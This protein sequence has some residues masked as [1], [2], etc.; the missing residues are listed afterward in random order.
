[1]KTVKFVGS[2]TDTLKLVKLCIELEYLKLF[3]YEKKVA[4]R[5]RQKIGSCL[6]IH[7]TTWLQP[8][9]KKIILYSDSC[10]GQ[11]RD[12]KVVLMLKHFLVSSNADVIAQWFFSIR[13]QL[14]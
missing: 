13:A 9:V 11:N 7:L 10:G 4:F 3:Q 5:G 2:K 14:Q 8:G 12:I 6:L 1:M